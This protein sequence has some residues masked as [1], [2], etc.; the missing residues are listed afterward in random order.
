MARSEPP[1]KSV[2]WSWL[3]MLAMAGILLFAL[4]DTVSAD[5][6]TV[7]LPRFPSI[8]PDGSEIVFS[9]GGDLWRASADGG[10][11]IRLTRHRLDD[12]HSSWSPD[13]EWITFTSMR[14][15][16]MNLWRI[17]RDGTHLTQLTHG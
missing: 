1:G 4:L 3:A 7:A 6:S 10:R 15:G 13:G 12:L 11:A 9:W 17:H 14:D 5:S 8:S 2:A 16:Y